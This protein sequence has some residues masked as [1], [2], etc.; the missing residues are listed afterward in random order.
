MILEKNCVFYF[1]KVV[2][3]YKFIAMLL[4]YHKFVVHI[5]A[6]FYNN[7]KIEILLE[8]LQAIIGAIKLFAV[9]SFMKRLRNF[10]LIFKQNL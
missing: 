8:K 5:F 2:R 6:Q 9:A 1:T 3:Y 10:I 7:K 4:V